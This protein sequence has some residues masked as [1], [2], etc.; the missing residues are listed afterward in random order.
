MVSDFNSIKA[1]EF[2]LE[3]AV[4]PLFKKTSADFDEGGAGGL[5]MNHLGVDGVGRVIFDSSDVVMVEDEDEYQ[6]TDQDP[7]IDIKEL[8]CEYTIS[9]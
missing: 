6:G 9:S 8:Q 7:R 3:L 5:L 4:D 2:E 1:K